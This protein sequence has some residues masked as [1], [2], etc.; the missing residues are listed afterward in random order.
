MLVAN[1]TLAQKKG[2][3]EYSV[4]AEPMDSS[5]N[6]FLMARMLNKSD[7]QF[8]FWGKKKEKAA[9]V[10]GDFF[11]FKAILD[12]KAN[13]CLKKVKDPQNKFYSIRDIGDTTANTVKER[14]HYT[15]TEDTTY[16]LGVLC[17][18]ATCQVG[19]VELVCWYA[20][21][22]PHSFEKV[23]FLNVDVPGMPLEFMNIEGKVL[24]VFRAKSI[25]KLNKDEKK[26]F[27]VVPPPDFVKSD[28][29]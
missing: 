14:Y 24:S 16:I 17:K 18:K 1:I 15:L 13:K 27:E 28:K 6:S 9:L 19:D 3:V 5:A 11:E 23:D 4:V 2:V 26:A 7:F 22:I 20:P 10:I 21:S 8:S 25:R 29:I 12:Y